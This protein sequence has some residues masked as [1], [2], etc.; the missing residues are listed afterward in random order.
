M[1]DRYDLEELVTNSPD[2]YFFD[3]DEDG[4]PELC[5]ADTAGTFVCK[6]D[7]ETDGY[8]SWYDNITSG[9]CI[10]GSRKIGYTHNDDEEYLNQMD[11]DGQI[12]TR[13]EYAALMHPQRYIVSIPG[14]MERLQKGQIPESMKRKLYYDGQNYF[15]R[16]TKEQYKDLIKGLHDAR[17]Q[18]EEH[19]VPLSY[20]IEDI[21]NEEYQSKYNLNYKHKHQ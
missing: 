7:P 8:V 19:T 13:I 17:K 10:L 11:K 21:E 14:Y 3:M 16:V 6:Y 9:G 15:I 4:A 5:I 12:E 18:A 2:M 20:F 1:E